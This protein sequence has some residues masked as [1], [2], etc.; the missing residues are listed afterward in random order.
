MPDDWSIRVDDADARRQLRLIEVALSD[1]RPFWPAVTRL[2]RGWMR[3]QFNTEGEFAG[4]RWQPLSPV[5]ALQKAR[6]YPG[7]GIL[8]A[9]GQLR[10]AADAPLRTVS[11]HAL[12]LT[13]DD[14]GKE[15]GPVLQ[16]HQAG[17]GVPRRPL[18]FGDPL[19]PLAAIELEQAAADYVAELFRRS[20]P[21]R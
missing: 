21:A 6:R 8:H 20:R 4:Q 16:Y 11:P 5:Y 15:H 19:P 7:R 17:D 10:R 13:I 12:T 2:F 18:V 14:A 1:L 9:S 3:R